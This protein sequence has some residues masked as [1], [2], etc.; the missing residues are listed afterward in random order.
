MNDYLEQAV[1]CL[2]R[3]FNSDYIEYLEFNEFNDKRLEEILQ[4]L[5]NNLHT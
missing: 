1:K 4:N 5:E 2:I 3:S